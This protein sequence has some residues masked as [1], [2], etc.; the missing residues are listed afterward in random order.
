MKTTN[1]KLMLV[2]LL[3]A[4]CG[5]P[6]PA[7]APAVQ[8]ED[9]APASFDFVGGLALRAN[10]PKELAQW[11]T[12]RFGLSIT[13]EFP[14]GVA[15]GFKSGGPCAFPYVRSSCPLPSTCSGGRTSAGCNV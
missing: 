5:Q 14:G 7:A 6:R 3:A 15:G 12:Q 1:M 8:H 10:Q 9:K 2:L 4:A 11:Y 13:F